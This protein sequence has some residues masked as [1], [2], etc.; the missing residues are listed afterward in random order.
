VR[1]LI[2]FCLFVN[3]SPGW[4]PFPATLTG[5]GPRRR[6]VRCRV[7]RICWT[8]VPLFLWSVGPFSRK[9]H[10]S[11]SIPSPGPAFQCTSSSQLPGLVGSGGDFCGLLKEN[12]SGR[13]FGLN[14]F[15]CLKT[16]RVGNPF[17]SHWPARAHIGDSYCS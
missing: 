5:E 4:G 2:C 7:V 11:G 13:F 1:F 3:H 12:V 9:R 17:R 10:S 6:L 14:I 8:V 16:H 15:I